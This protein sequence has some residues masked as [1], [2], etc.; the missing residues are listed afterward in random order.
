MKFPLLIIVREASDCQ[1]L[2]WKVCMILFFN[3]HYNKIIWTVTVIV[4]LVV[5]CI[6]FFFIYLFSFILHPE[7]RPPLPKLPSYSSYHSN[8]FSKKVEV[9]SGLPSTLAHQVS[10]RLGVS[11]PTVTHTLTLS[12]TP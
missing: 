4:K 6:V 10:S 2:S 12:L 11:S 7:G 9:S 5:S 3:L 8:L 1:C